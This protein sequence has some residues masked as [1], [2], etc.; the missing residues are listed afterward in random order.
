M[1]Y[2]Y[3]VFYELPNDASLCY[4]WAWDLLFFNNIGEKRWRN[5]T[6]STH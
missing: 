2:M 4:K 5:M 3:V 1:S 6:M